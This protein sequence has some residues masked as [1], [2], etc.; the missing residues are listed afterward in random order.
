MREMRSGMGRQRRLRRSA[1]IGLTAMAAIAV[2]GSVAA[3]QAQATPAAAARPAGGGG[4]LSISKAFFGN[5]VEPYT[6]KE[7]AV[8]R[9]TLSNARGMSVDIL[10]FGGIVQQINL[11]GRNGH[12]ADVVLGFST[13]ADYVAKDS[14]PVA[15]N[16]APLADDMGSAYGNRTA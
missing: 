14:P 11:P 5:A 9:Y 4:G 6:G 3:T 2:G 1:L 8:Y 10:T 13:L 15:A 12:K 16:G 7:T